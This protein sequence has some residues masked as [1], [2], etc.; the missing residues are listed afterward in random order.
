MRKA[1][2]HAKLPEVKAIDAILSRTGLEI[3]G[4]ISRES[5]ETAKRKIEEL[6][7]KNDALLIERAVFVRAAG[8]P[9]DYSDVHYECEL[10]GD[11]GYVETRM[12]DCMKRALAVA[13]YESS[14]LG[15]LIRT[16]SFDNFSLEYYSGAYA[17]EVKA[18][19]AMLRKF[20]ESFDDSTY[21]NF[22]LV[23][24]TG[25]GKTHLSTSVAKTV[26]DRG[27]DVHYTTSIRMLSDFEDR[28]FK[29]NIGR[30]DEIDLSRYY[31]AQLL[32]L[33]DL[34]TDMVTQF[35]VSCLYDVINMRISNRKSTIINTNLNK[36]EIEAKYG[37]R[38]ASRLFGEY[39]ARRF[40]GT[41]VRFQKIAKK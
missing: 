29:K 22:L 26:I 13:G 33:D 20:A 41:D 12:C 1:E 40:A 28:R 15:G 2:L 7:E 31:D 10:C 30:E 39:I 17:E 32:I 11:T 34:G 16:Q 6:K 8:Y 3:M 36:K 18:N 23:G 19:V 35:S 9:E 27:G 24:A 21:C 25:L 5:A 37:E 4:I 38:I 14:G